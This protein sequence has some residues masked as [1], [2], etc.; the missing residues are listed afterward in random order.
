MFSLLEVHKKEKRA[1][2]CRFQSLSPSFAYAA[3][4]C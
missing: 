2:N 1:Y 3:K 4:E